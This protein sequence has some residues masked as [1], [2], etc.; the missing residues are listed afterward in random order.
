MCVCVCAD[1]IILTFKWLC[2]NGVR[3]CIYKN[4][5]KQYQNHIMTS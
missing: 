4:E 1:Y 2:G 5:E 3:D